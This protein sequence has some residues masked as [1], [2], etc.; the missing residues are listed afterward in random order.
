MT[1]VK[2]RGRKDRLKQVTEVDTSPPVWAGLI[3][4]RLKPLSPDEVV[5]VEEVALSLMER[6]GLSQS[7][8]SLVEKVTKAGGSMTDGGRLLFPRKLVK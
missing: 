5:L 8:P 6:L 4:G 7:I 1:K 2:R 3:G